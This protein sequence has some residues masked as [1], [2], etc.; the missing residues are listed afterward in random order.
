MIR[1][2]T[3]CKAKL[4]MIQQIKDRTMRNKMLNLLMDECLFKA[5]QELIIKCSNDFDKLRPKDRRALA[6]HERAMKSLLKTRYSRV[7]KKRI[8]NQ[9]GGFWPSLIPIGISLISELLR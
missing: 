1:N 5:V 7:N 2:I 8:T 9:I 6:K 4:L 3:R